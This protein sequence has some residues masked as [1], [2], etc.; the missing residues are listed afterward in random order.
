MHAYTAVLGHKP[1]TFW[2]EVR[3][4][5]QLLFPP[6]KKRSPICVNPLDMAKRS[7]APHESIKC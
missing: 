5:G 4:P 2:M 6:K 1:S 7:R 3:Q